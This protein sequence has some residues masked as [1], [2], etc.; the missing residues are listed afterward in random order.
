[1]GWTTGY[2]G[3]GLAIWGLDSITVSSELRSTI[4]IAATSPLTAGKM[5]MAGL[6][7]AASCLSSIQHQA[8]CYAANTLVGGEREPHSRTLSGLR[9]AGGVW[10]DPPSGSSGG[11]LLAGI[12]PAEL[13]A[14]RGRLEAFADDIFESLPRKDQR[15]RGAC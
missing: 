13:A 8:A 12:T 5:E 4:A 14:I 3:L 10:V 9:L 1:M 6:G 15:A 7:P 11:K 2:G